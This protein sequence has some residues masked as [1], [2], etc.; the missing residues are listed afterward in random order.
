MA[1]ASIPAKEA[2]CPDCGATFKKVTS[3]K[4][5]KAC[6]IARETCQDCGAT[7]DARIG[8]RFC[9]PCYQKQNHGA[10][11]PHWRG[12][13]EAKLQRRSEAAKRQRAENPEP[14]RWKLVRLKYGVTREQYLL[15]LS[16]QG[17]VC[18]VC[19]KPEK[20][21]VKSTGKTRP[22]AIDHD[23]ETDLVCGLL[24]AN[25]NHGL[26]CFSDD[27]DTLVAAA[28]YLRQANMATS[29]AQR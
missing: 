19:H 25:C 12:G 8:R 20:A 10:A 11:S 21:T 13:R 26:G 2:P 29:I 14:F 4:R 28:E 17:G 16:E 1:P 23:H 18:A 3:Q 15:M 9:W 24:C 7:R 6:R 22:L 5:C 27:P